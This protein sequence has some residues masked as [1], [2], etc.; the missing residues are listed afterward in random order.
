MAP[1][2]EGKM[3]F[4]NVLFSPP[5]VRSSVT[6]PTVSIVIQLNCG[7]YGDRDALQPSSVPSK[8]IKHISTFYYLN[9]PQVGCQMSLQL[10]AL[11]LLVT[12]TESV[13]WSCL[14][15]LCPLK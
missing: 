14:A 13:R 6:E 7:W 11:V 3:L 2:Y 1:V 9:L 8:I 10:C 4:V 15:E 12:V 5:P